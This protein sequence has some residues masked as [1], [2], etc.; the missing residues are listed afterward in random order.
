MI[1]LLIMARRALGRAMPPSEPLL[2]SLSELL[3][4]CADKLLIPNQGTTE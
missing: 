3:L 1:S 2:V 4:I